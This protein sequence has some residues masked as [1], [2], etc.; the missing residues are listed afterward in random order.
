MI[1]LILII[2][3]NFLNFLKKYRD[4]KGVTDKY[5]HDLLYDILNYV[6]QLDEKEIDKNHPT[7]KELM[8]RISLYEKK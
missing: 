1:I 8:R 4:L 3:M 6:N 7:Y 5:V 2:W